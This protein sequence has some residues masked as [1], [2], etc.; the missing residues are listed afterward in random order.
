[1]EF[2][3]PYSPDLNPIERMFRQTCLARESQNRVAPTESA[4]FDELLEAFDIAFRTITPEDV[5]RGSL[6]VVIPHLKSVR[7]A[8]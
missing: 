3:P 7:N 1:L 8:L 6:I 2:L 4:H 5:V